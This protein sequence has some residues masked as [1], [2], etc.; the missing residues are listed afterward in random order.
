MS[1]K[2][3]VLLAIMAAALLF[4]GAVRLHEVRVRNRQAAEEASHQ[5]G[6]PF[7]F[8]HIPVSLAAPEAELPMAPIEYRPQS[9]NVYLEDAP[10]TPMQQRKQARDTIASILADFQHDTALA[11]FNQEVQQTSHG[12]VQ[13]LEDLSTQN[14]MQIVQQNPE[15]QGV[16]EKH[17]KN[18]DFSKAIEE[19]FQNPQFRQSVQTLQQTEQTQP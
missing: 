2:S 16:V 10:L 17:L 4:M 15:I 1:K 12:R 14:L 11:G 5:D 18:K 6:E 13:G 7:T 9:Q 19:I 3:Y 8:Q